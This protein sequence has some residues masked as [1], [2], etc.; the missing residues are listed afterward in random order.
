MRLLCDDGGE[1]LFCDNDT[2]AHRLWGAPATD[3]Y[4][5]DGVNDYV[6]EGERG[7]VNPQRLGTK[8]AIHY[9]LTVAAGGAARFRLRLVEDGVAARARWLR[10]RNAAAP[11]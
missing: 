4:F 2:N 11:A 8:A 1:F 6:V 10:R 7:A 5:K 9:R 3:G